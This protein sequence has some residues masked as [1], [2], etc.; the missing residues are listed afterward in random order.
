MQPNERQ[1]HQSP[2]Q[3]NWA[4]SS[5]C[6]AALP[7]QEFRYSLTTPQ[8]DHPNLQQREKAAN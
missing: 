8:R 5:T 6:T 3:L 2:Q 4:Q 7:W 1:H